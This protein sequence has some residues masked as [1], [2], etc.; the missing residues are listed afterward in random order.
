M[1]LSSAL[2]FYAQ[3]AGAIGGTLGIALTIVKIREHFAARPRAIVRNLAPKLREL[4]MKLDQHKLTEFKDYYEKN[5]A[6]GGYDRDLRRVAPTLVLMMESLKSGEIAPLV[7]SGSAP[8]EWKE[9]LDN[10]LRGYAVL[11]TI[12]EIDRVLEEAEGI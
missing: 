11:M 2:S 3:I 9:F 6:S 8:A 12:R 7:G 5:F 4:R 10:V 1:G